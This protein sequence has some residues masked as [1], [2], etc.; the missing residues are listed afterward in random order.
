M[1]IRAKILQL[2]EKYGERVIH[3][4]DALIK[5]YIFDEVGMTKE[6]MIKLNDLQFT[7]ESLTKIRRNMTREGIFKHPKEILEQR[8]QA[9]VRFNRGIYDKNTTGSIY[10]Y[11][12]TNINK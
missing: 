9:R 8:E 7:I 12:A 3:S 11:P 2:Y 6:Q 5:Y 1:T 10:A 4:N